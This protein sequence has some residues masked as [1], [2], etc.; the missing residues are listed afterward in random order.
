MVAVAVVVQ[1]L[2]GLLVPQALAVVEAAVGASKTSRF[3]LQIS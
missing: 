2:C 1:G 3:L